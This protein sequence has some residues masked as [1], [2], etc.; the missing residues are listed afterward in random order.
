MSELSVRDIS[1]RC[2]QINYN[3]IINIEKFNFFL[4]NFNILL[5]K[6]DDYNNVFIKKKTIEVYHD[7]KVS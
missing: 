1:M 4:L 6:F 5:D 2:T 7:G 3:T